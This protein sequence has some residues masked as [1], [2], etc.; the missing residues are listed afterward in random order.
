MQVLGPLVQVTVEGIVRME[1]ECG[2]NVI[3]ARVL[4]AALSLNS[5]CL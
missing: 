3:Q 5:E 1:F 4:S 2:K